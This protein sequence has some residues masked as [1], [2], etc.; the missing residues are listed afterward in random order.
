M[1]AD[2][3]NAFL[4][5]HLDP[6]GSI[7]ADWCGVFLRLA[8]WLLLAGLLTWSVVLLARS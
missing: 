6:I 7:L 5:R 4:D 8:P 3:V 1:K 2:R